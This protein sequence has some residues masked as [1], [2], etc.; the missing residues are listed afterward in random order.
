MKGAVCL[1]KRAGQKLKSILKKQSNWRT[2]QR[3]ALLQ[4]VRQ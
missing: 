3:V 4:P 1:E 2:S